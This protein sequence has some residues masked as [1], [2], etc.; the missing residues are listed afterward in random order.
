MP[1]HGTHV[2]L[3]VR[4]SLSP[5]PPPPSPLPREA[6]RSRRGPPLPPLTQDCFYAMAPLGMAD[7]F[8][9]PPHPRAN[10][11]ASPG[12]QAAYPSLSVEYRQARGRPARARRALARPQR[13][14]AKAAC[15][16]TSAPLAAGKG[17]GTFAL[18]PGG[19]FA[20]SNQP[21]TASTDRASACSPAALDAGQN[22]RS[23][24]VGWHSPSNSWGRDGPSSAH[25]ARPSRTS[26]AT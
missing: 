12:R 25:R 19:F 16:P 13:M 9:P 5:L 10:S 3:F 17:T 18:W 22:T 4:P 7:S 26:P 14:R 20:G 21:T 23:L 1:Y 2:G 15:A 24:T 6:S 8:L 11:G